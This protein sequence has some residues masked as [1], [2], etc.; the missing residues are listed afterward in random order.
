M[1]SKP[2]REPK[3]LNEFSQSSFPAE[4]FPV[5][6]QALNHCPGPTVIPGRV[7]AGWW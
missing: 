6:Q 2:Q 3:E 4:M 7:G 1:V 5:N